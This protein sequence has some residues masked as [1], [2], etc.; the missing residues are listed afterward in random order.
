M[1]YTRYPKRSAINNYYPLP[2]EI[3]AL[4][5]SANEIAIYSYLLYIE[6]RKTYQCYPSYKTI[7]QAVRLSRN[8]VR[9]F[10]LELENKRLITTEPTSIFTKDGR[11][12]NG[13]LLYTIRPIQEAINYF[14][15]QQLERY[16]KQSA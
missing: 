11:K 14:H 2:N 9:K 1:K 3:F 12:R 10:V 7:G 8:T 15:E 5:L 13:S 6:D 16:S 4:N